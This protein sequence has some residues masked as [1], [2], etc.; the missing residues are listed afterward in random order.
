[1]QNKIE[2]KVLKVKGFTSEGE[3]IFTEYKK[4]FPHFCT[5]EGSPSS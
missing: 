2:S 3:I 5:T 1:M 4:G